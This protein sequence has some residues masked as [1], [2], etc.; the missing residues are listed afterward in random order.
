MLEDGHILTWLLDGHKLW[1][2]FGKKLP[3]SVAIENE[4]KDYIDSQATPENWMDECLVQGDG[5]WMGSSELL[6][7][8]ICWKDSRGEHAVSMTVLG[9]AMS[10]RFK[11]KRGSKG[12]LYEAALK[13]FEINHYSK[14][15]G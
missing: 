13:S 8:Y 11:K 3:P 5:I 12:F 10:K 6:R 2:G 14:S 4:V 1:L 7:N 9:E 15:V